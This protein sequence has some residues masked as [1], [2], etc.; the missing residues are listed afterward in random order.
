MIGARP[1]FI[2]A[3]PLSAAIRQYHVEVLVHTGQHCD[4]QMSHV[5]SETL[6]IPSPDHR[7][8]VGSGRMVSKQRRCSWASNA[9]CVTSSR[10]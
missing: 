7:R 6:G 2:K 4:A 1:Q 9:S 10:M 8:A 5:F 3:T